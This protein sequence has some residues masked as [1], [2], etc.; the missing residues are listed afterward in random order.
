MLRLRVAEVARAQGVSMHKLSQRAEISYNVVKGICKN[1]TRT[2]NTDTIN[3]LVSALGVPVTELI[4]DV[5]QEFMKCL[6]S[7]DGMCV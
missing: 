2:V 1:P 7:N 3:Q 4:E 6:N 5:P